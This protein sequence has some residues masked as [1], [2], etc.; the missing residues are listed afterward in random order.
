M[1]K[2]KI[3]SFFAFALLFST[4]V[5][6]EA[7]NHVKNGAFSEGS[8]FWFVLSKGRYLKNDTLGDNLLSEAGKGYYLKVGNIVTEAPKKPA[9]LLINSRIKDL[10]G[11]TRYTL[12]FD[13]RASQP[14]SCLV[15]LGAP[16]NEGPQK[17]NLEGA[18]PVK[19]VQVATE[20]QT[21]E[22]PFE[23][24]AG[25]VLSFPEDREATLL[26]F[27]VGLLK[28]VVLRNVSVV[29]TEQLP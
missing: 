13:I 6:A 17:N 5:S 14:G 3:L 1:M 16:R 22:I 15:G 18:I 19:E 21:V 29:S 2:T 9:H 25:Q 7:Q 4:L 23:Y 27:R 26:Q 28:D 20:W 11:G 24:N 8:R 12:R 10:Q